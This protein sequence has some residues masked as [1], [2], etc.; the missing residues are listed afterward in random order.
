MPKITFIEHDGTVHEIDAEIGA[1][2]MESAMKGGAELPGTIGW[3]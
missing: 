3:T 1:T 2:V